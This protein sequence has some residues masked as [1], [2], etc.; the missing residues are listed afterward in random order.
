MHGERVVLVGGVERRHNGCA[1]EWGTPQ[2]GFFGLER[3]GSVSFYNRE[4][5]ADFGVPTGHIGGVGGR[6]RYV[7]AITV[8]TQSAIRRIRQQRISSV[9]FSEAWRMSIIATES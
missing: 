9:G 6:D 1:V 4:L 8:V 5:G 7:D 3:K 2:N